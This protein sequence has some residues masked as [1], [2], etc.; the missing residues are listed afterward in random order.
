MKR[1]FALSLTL[2]LAAACL[3]ATAASEAPRFI[4]PP[5]QL[6]G[7]LKISLESIA[8]ERQFGILSEDEGDELSEG[9][10]LVVRLI[11]EDAKGLT[12]DDHYAVRNAVL[13]AS[14][15]DFLS[16]G[17]ETTADAPWSF[18]DRRLAPLIH[19][20][21][22][23]AVDTALILQDQ[24]VVSEEQAQV[25]AQRLASD[26]VSA[27]RAAENA[28][29]VLGPA[30]APCRL[31]VSGEP[32]PPSGTA[33]DLCITVQESRAA[34]TRFSFP[35]VQPGA[36][37]TR[38]TKAGLAVTIEK[39]RRFRFSG[40]DVFALWTSVEGSPDV[41]WRVEL[42][43]GDVT[44][45][46]GTGYWTRAWTVTPDRRFV[47]GGVDPKAKWVSVEFTATR[48]SSA[49]EHVFDFKGLVVP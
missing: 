48:P 11:V 36:A 39:V 20:A 34:E 42:Q 49:R 28:Q 6:Q 16:C 25:L 5:F 23:A 10:A 29:R 8:R 26:H 19:G 32:C 30:L 33:L 7:D 9:P 46:S 41:E 35:R 27:R 14:G 44:H 45:E 40:V 24:T 37:S 3:A 47:L 18:I 2:L 31:E 38:R 12:F 15:W 4:E 17:F 43:R 13:N 1:C 22:S 21:T